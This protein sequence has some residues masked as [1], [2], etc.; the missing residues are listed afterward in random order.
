MPRPAWA[1]ALGKCD[2]TAARWQAAGMIVVRYVGRM[3]YVVLDA[4][5]ARLRGEEKPRRGRPRKVA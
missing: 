1:A 2:R 3:P 4:T 5:A